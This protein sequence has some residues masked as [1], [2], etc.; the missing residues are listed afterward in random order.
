MTGEQ[1]LKAVLNAPPGTRSKI[2]LGG[3]D[4]VMARSIAAKSS[5]R[6]IAVRAALAEPASADSAP[7]SGSDPFGETVAGNF[8]S[9]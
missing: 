8:V 5:M 4:H 6:A 7:A 3:D 1:F 9:V 2:E